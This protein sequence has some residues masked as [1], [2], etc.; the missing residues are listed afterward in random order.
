M[1]QTLSTG[2]V[3]VDQPSPGVLLVRVS[4]DCRDQSHRPWLSVVREML[5]KIPET[6]SLSFETSG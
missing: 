2:N 1:T 3:V 5:D 4:G 6:K